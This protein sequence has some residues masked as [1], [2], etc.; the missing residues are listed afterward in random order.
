MANLRLEAALGIGE[1]VGQNQAA[2]GVGVQHF[3]SLARQRSQHVIGADCAAVGHI[4]DQPDHAHGVAAGLA[5]RERHQRAGDGR[6]ARHVALHARHAAARL[7][8]QAAGI[9]THALAD[10]GDRLTVL[11]AAVP[12]HPD[13]KLAFT[14]AALAH[15]QQRAKALLLHLRLAENFDLDAQLR[16][17]LSC[18]AA[19]A[20]STG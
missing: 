5:R 6:G 11:L 19:S 1:R 2:F 3:D 13:H 12:L 18:S 10:E 9:E 15:A 7:D 16:Q 14:L 8:R 17:L 20:K 4:L